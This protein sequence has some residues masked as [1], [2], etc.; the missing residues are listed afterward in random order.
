MKAEVAAL[1]AMAFVR[2]AVRTVSR[3]RVEVPTMSPSVREARRGRRAM[4]RAVDAAERAVQHARAGT[5]PIAELP[6][7][8]RRLR[9]LAEVID[10]SLL[11]SSR[12]GSAVGFD[13]REIGELVRTAQEIE[14]AASSSLREVTAPLARRLAEDARRETQ[15]LEAGLGQLR[16]LHLGSES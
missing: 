12:A 13:G 16:R 8:C 10:R 1:G 9:G 14:R 3:W 11:I 5:A 4:W 7:L 15:A 6:V 2:F